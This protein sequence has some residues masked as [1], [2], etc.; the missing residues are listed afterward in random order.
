M[1]DIE[2]N[3]LNLDLCV[4]AECSW[5]LFHYNFLW[6][7]YF[8]LSVTTGFFFF[9]FDSLILIIVLL[10]NY[11][12]WHTHSDYFV[13]RDLLAN[14]N[15]ILIIV[16]SQLHFKHVDTLILTISLS[17]FLSSLV[18]ETEI[19]W[20]SDSYTFSEADVASV[21]ILK[22]GINA[23]DVGKCWKN[24]LYSSR[25][26]LGMKAKFGWHMASSAWV[27][28]LCKIQGRT[29]NHHAVYVMFLLPA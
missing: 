3:F 29:T 28:R 10:R 21:R 11:Y 14:L 2:I 24:R 18:G 6:H 4:T 26:H 9:F 15:L 27:S 1:Y 22:I 12:F 13:T 7:A 17:L 25:G 19:S 20:E 8:D 5:S 16:S 23:V